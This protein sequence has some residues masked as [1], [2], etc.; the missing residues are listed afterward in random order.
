MNHYPPLSLSLYLSPACMIVFRCLEHSSF[1]SE[2]NALSLN[3]FTLLLT[4]PMNHFVTFSSSN[5]DNNV[6]WKPNDPVFQFQ[7][8][9]LTNC[10]I[11]Q[12][13]RQQMKKSI[14]CVKT[15]EIS[16]NVRHYEINVCFR[17][18]QWIT[19]HEY[20]SG[21]EWA[22]WNSVD[23]ADLWLYI[24]VSFGSVYV[25]VCVCFWE[26]ISFFSSNVDRK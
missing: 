11:S 23:L 13:Q 24:N 9:I 25:Y 10:F 20:L 14:V 18:A 1:I 17:Q 15:E 21:C 19:V 22:L 8:K 16:P 7:W 12:S 26:N 4:L 6:Q 5:S 3:C 2:S